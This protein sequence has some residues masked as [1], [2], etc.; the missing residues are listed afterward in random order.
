MGSRP[1][2]DDLPRDTAAAGAGH[3]GAAAVDGVV[4]GLL[5]ERWST[6]K[7]GRRA[8]AQ[9]QAA[10]HACGGGCWWPRLS[11]AAGSGRRRLSSQLPP[12]YPESEADVNPVGKQT[13]LE[14]EKERRRATAEPLRRRVPQAP[15]ARPQPHQGVIR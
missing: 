9:A 15:S 7:G 2:A 4:S 8:E 10:A 11:V 14:G 1:L 12:E 3:A 13:R 5:T 6:E